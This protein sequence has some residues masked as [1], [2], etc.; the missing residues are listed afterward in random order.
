MRVFWELSRRAFQ[1]Q[2]TYRAATLAGLATNFFFGVLRAS[3]LVAL[4]GARQEVAG[5]TLQG[6]VT[7]TAISQAAI[8]FLSLFSW[9]DLMNSV[10]TGSVAS[11]LLKPMGY[12]RFWMAQDL[13]RATTQFLLRGLPILFAYAIFFRIVVPRGMEQWTALAVTIILAWMVSFAWRFLVNLA[14][15]WVPNAMGIMRFAFIMTWLFSGFIMPLQY[16]PEWFYKLCL[17]TPFPYMVNSIVEVYLGLLS[18]HALF[19]ALLSQ[20]AWV[21]I[22]IGVGQLVLRSGI[23][24]L[25][26]LGG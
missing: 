16:Y 15:F 3:V 25:V 6:A 5:I 9:Y 4:Y 23:K 26:I 14:S 10:Y 21:A 8:G 17:W 7:Y 12:F 20:L 1:R 2:L 18:G 13:G 19:Y 24:R 11:D 22:L